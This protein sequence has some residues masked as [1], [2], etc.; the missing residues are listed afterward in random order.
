MTNIWDLKRGDLFRLA[1]EFDPEQRVWQFDHM[2][3]MYSFAFNGK[4]EVLNWSG[5]VEV[6]DE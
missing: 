4:G 5:S 3:G 1:P 2:D 6:V